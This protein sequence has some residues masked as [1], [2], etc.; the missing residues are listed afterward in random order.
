MEFLALHTKRK[1]CGQ[2]E[3]TP[4][5]LEESSCVCMPSFRYVASFFSLA[6]EPFLFLSLKFIKGYGHIDIL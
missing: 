5:L 2:M 1:R 3:S 6:K 4:I